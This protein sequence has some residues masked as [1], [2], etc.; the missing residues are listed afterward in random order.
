M[1]EKPKINVKKRN[2]AI[3]S[4]IMLAGGFSMSEYFDNYTGLY[5]WGWLSGAF[6][7]LFWSYI[8]SSIIW[9]IFFQRREFT[10]VMIYVT[11]AITIMSYLG[12]LIVLNS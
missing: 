3:L 10:Q 1:S 11:F 6:G 4:V 12:S 5:G 9:A 8:L 2:W 7:I